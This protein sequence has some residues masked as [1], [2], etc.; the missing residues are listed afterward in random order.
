MP[1]LAISFNERKKVEML[2]A[3]LKT[4]LRFEHMRL[5]GLT[6]ARDKFHLA[7]MVQN[8]RHMARPVAAAVARARWQAEVCVPASGRLYSCSPKRKAGSPAAQLVGFSPA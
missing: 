5:P 6:G 1:Q 3:Y 8:L 4:T 7:T 2:F